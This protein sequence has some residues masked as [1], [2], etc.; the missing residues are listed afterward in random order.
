MLVEMYRDDSKN[1]GLGGIPTEGTGFV[2]SAQQPVYRDPLVSLVIQGGFKLDYELENDA[3]GFNR[4]I[5]SRRSERLEISYSLIR[6][7][8]VTRVVYVPPFQ[9]E[10]EIKIIDEL[11]EILSIPG[12]PGR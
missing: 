12:F 2:D 6:G 4:L 11:M 3:F 7:G 5:F 9:L 10:R 1:I 8:I